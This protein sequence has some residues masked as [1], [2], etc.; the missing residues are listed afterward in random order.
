VIGQTLGPAA[1]MR[2]FVA[3]VHRGLDEPVVLLGNH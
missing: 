2:I 1:L 3:V